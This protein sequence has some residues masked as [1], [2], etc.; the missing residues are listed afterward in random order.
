MNRIKGIL[1]AAASSSTF[2]LAP[3]FSITLLLAGFSS[4]EV[5]SYRWG[6][7]AIT[8]TIIGM[9]SGCNFRL[10]RRDFIV[11]FCLSLFRA[12]TSFSLIVAYQNIASGVASTIH[13]MYPL[14]VALV[15]MFFFGE[16][17]SIWVIIAVL[18]SLFGASM[19]SSGEL[20]VENGNTAIGLI[21]AC[22]SV[23]S[24][25][26]YIIGV[27]KTRAV[28]INST[29]LTCYVMGMGT[30]FYL[31]GAGCT[32]GLRMVTDG[33]TWLIILGLALPATAISNITL[34]QAI[35]YAGPTLTSILGAMEPLT[36]VVIGV[37][38]FHE[39]FTMNS[40]V[41]ILLILLA[42]GIVV[43]RERK[44]KG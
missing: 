34:V 14:A 10:D 35:K 6:V 4:F 24:Y 3:F 19:L 31:I 36:A 41:G 26:G 17:K 2:G 15:M 40:A 44:I 38:A 32:S 1:Y 11:V 42:V 27:R 18:M 30:I 5:L 37:L 20:N 33:Y 16:K 25:A 39:L 9:L 29:V 13:F 12:A 8:L 43:F 22:V 7:A 21:W 23:F 28:Q